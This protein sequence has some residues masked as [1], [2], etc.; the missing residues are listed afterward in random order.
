MGR[1]VG[2]IISAGQCALPVVQAKCEPS[3]SPAVQ[4]GAPAQDRRY[5]GHRRAVQSKQQS[6]PE[7][8]GVQT[9]CNLI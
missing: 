5:I 2:L 7:Y 3:G 9:K 6:H 1:V 8:H 4:I